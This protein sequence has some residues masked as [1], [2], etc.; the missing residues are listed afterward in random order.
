LEQDALEARARRR[1]RLVDL[2]QREVDVTPPE[3]RRALDHEQV[4]GAKEHRRYPAH[5]IC[6]ALGCAVD[7]DSLS[8]VGATRGVPGD[9]GDLDLHPTGPRLNLCDDASSR[10]DITQELPAYKL[11]VGLGANGTQCGQQIDSFQEVGFA[12]RV[13]ANEERSFS[14]KFDVEA[15]KIA[16][17]KEL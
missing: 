6:E 11:D 15:L 13:I 8:R 7:L 10:Q 1:I 9:D 12:L 3:R 16:V 17:V 14:G 4:I 5:G 2:H